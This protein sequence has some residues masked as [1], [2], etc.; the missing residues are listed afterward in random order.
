MMIREKNRV[1]RLSIPVR[2]CEG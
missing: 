1:S 2:D